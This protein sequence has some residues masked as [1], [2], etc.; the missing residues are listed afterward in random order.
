LKDSASYDPHP[1]SQSKGV[2]CMIGGIYSRE[3]CPE[4][5]RSFKDDGKTG[6]YCPKHNNQKASSFFIKFKGVYRTFNHYDS[7]GRFLEGI[8][9]KEDEGTFDLRDYQAGNPLGF[10]TLSEKWLNIKS[11]EVKTGIITKR[12]YLNIRNYIKTAQ[13]FFDDITIK[14]IQY[15]ELEDF[16][17]SLNVN[18]KTISN[19]MSCLRNFFTWAWRREKKSFRQYEF[20]EF[21][22][23]K[24]TLGFRNV[25]DKETQEAVLD[26]IW[27]IS[28]HL[29]PKIYL[30]IRWLATYISVRPKELLSLKE[31]HIDTGNGYFLF[32]HPKEKRYKAVPLLDEDVETLKNFPPALPNLYFFRHRPAKGQRVF[33]E[34]APFGQDL[35]RRYWKKACKN[36][37]IEDVD[38]YGGTRHSSARALRKHFSPEEIKRATMHSTN[39]AFERYFQIE[40]DDV[41]MIYAKS[42][43][44][45]K[46]TQELKDVCTTFAPLF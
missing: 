34:G 27:N 25:I 2:L 33:K 18:A 4:C 12:H 5:G 38:L 44:K 3:R 8:R 24:F 30:A 39:K 7:A 17:S 9:Y 46:H 13:D 1:L 45:E 6:L 42:S 26:E 23:C 40:S 16:K 37:G 36:L 11:E 22:E 14:K 21:P 19:Y 41:R 10:K 31:G 32:P 20:P 29:N 43:G 15:G 28:H 35:L